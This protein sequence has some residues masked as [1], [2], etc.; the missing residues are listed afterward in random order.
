MSFFQDT[1]L[2][3]LRSAFITLKFLDISD[4]VLDIATTA[5]FIDFLS[6]NCCSKMEILVMLN[7]LTTETAKMLA[8]GLTK[9]QRANK[10][11]NLKQVV[12]SRNNVQPD[13]LI[14]LITNFEGFDN[15]EVVVI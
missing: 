10:L 13:G 4:N 1:I 3:N 5:V 2:G 12:F 11:Q 7:C 14:P 9:I 6:S 15:L 8:K